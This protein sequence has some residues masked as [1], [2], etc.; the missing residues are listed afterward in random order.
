MYA[1]YTGGPRACGGGVGAGPRLVRPGL[2]WEAGE[3][4]GLRPL[5]HDDQPER[6]RLLAQ[7][8]V[9][10]VVLRPGAATRHAAS[11]LRS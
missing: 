8:V 1:V 6:R 2:A 3:L 5:L 10:R 11:S 9:Q 4:E 7:V